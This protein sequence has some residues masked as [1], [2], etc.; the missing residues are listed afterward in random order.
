MT[1]KSIESYKDIMNP[2]KCETAV[3]ESITRIK[4]TKYYHKV[5]SS[6]WT[7]MFL[8]NAIDNALSRIGKYHKGDKKPIKLM[9]L[10][11]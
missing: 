7:I 1:F 3:K 2:F 10:L 5:Y 6:N 4:N 11:N 8:N 9:D